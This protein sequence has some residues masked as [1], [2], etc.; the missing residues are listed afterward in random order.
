MMVWSSLL[1]VAAATG[2]SFLIRKIALH[3]KIV[4]R[5]DLSPQRKDIKKRVPLLGGTAIWL[6][7]FIIT[8]LQL[9]D[10]TSGYLL[11]KHL[12]GIWLAGGI[13]II[14][15]GLDDVFNLSPLKQLI[16]PLV[17]CLVIIGSGIGVAYISNPFGNTISLTQIQWVL[18]TDHGLPYQITVW[19]D[20]F[21]VV[22]LMLTMY[23][24]KLL[25][26]V[27]GLVSGIGAI[28]GIIIGLLCLSTTVQQPETASLAFIFAGA[29]LGFLVWNLAPARLYLGEG[30][31]L[32]IGFMLGILAILSGGKI[33]TALLILG[34]PLLDLLAVIIRRVVIEHKSPF[35]GDLSHLHFQLQQRGWKTGQIIL[36]YYAITLA[37]GLSTLIFGGVIKI[38]MLG[39][40]LVLGLSLVLY[41]SL[42]TTQSQR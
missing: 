24:T 17:A 4:D 11:P 29:C 19:A 35:K 22:W 25:D 36:V 20:I 18:F 9:I 7:F 33:A 37:F 30:G 21:T 26:G 3:Y 40:L 41:A 6:V 8:A 34:L 2:V 38:I 5:P 32:F 14:G 1:A 16:F 39:I 28:G 23:T 31:A 42:H 10:L 15:G 13:I 12:A 27:D